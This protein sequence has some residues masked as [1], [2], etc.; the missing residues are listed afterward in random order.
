[1]LCIQISNLRVESHT[2][3]SHLHV[4]GDAVEAVG[5]LIYGGSDKMVASSNH[6]R[7]VLLCPWQFATI[8]CGRRIFSSSKF[9]ED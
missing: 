7:V 9:N 8:F 3:P 6:M 2:H 1:M 5:A 4:V